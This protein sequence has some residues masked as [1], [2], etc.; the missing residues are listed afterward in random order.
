VK[1]NDLAEE[2]QTCK[3]SNKLARRDTNLQKEQQS[4]T[5]KKWE[6][7]QLASHY[8]LFRIPV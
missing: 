4:K 3:K 2:I 6:A 7:A 5:K 8:L 1:H